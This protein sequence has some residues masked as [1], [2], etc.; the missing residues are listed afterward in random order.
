[1][2]NCKVLVFKG[3]PTQL[4]SQICSIHGFEKF[5]DEKNLKMQ[6]SKKW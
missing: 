5:E 1:M 6:S 3:T 2:K 4:Y